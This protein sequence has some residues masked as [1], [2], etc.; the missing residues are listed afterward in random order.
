MSLIHLNIVSQD[1]GFSTLSTVST[2]PAE[3][4]LGNNLLVSGSSTISPFLLQRY[5]ASNSEISQATAITGPNLRDQ[6]D[7]QFKDDNESKFLSDNNSSHCPFG[8]LS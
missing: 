7:I 8:Q 3:S 4:I 2:Q 6:S 1:S 5:L